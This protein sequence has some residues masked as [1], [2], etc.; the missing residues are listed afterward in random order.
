MQK[1]RAT[2]KPLPCIDIMRAVKGAAA[3]EKELGG[4]EKLFRWIKESEQ[5]RSNFFAWINTCIKYNG[6]CKK[7]SLGI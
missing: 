7:C 2:R 3:I 1:N 5:N 6:D 4:V